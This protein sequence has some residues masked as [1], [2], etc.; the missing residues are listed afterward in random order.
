MPCHHCLSN[1]ALFKVQSDVIRRLAAEK[2]C[3]FVGRC[4]DYILSRASSYNQDLTHLLHPP[5]RRGRIIQPYHSP[6]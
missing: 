5:A 3:V 2:S 1:D 6:Y 4:A